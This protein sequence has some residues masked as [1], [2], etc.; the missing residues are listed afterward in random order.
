M[1]ELYLRF[2]MER[3][4]YRLGQSQHRDKFVLRGGMMLPL[5]AGAMVRPTKDIDLSGKAHNSVE[6][7]VG[8]LRDCLETAVPADGIEFN[9]ESIRGVEINKDAKYRGVRV[10]FTAYLGETRCS[11]QVDVGFGD[12][13]TDGPIEL[14][15]PVLLNTLDSPKLLVYSRESSIA[16]K[17]HA[18]VLM[19]TANTRMKDFFD[20]FHFARTQQFQGKIL[21]RAIEA[22]F[23]YR[24][25]E[26]PSRPPAALCDEYADLE[27]PRREWPP[28]LRRYRVSM[29][30][31]PLS[32][33]IAKL[34]EFL[35]PPVLAA[36]SS[37]VFLEEWSPEGP[38]K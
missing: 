12:V 35:M 32:K 13:V 37:R 3:F 18:M 8:L 19:D 38:W 10:F 11:M 2:A 22:T 33:V 15:Y 27:V 20:I 9:L 7:V 21:A 23:K 24:A 36:A 5:F 30:D 4:L 14:D 34:R 25:T 6:N 28:T 31:L 17:F 29:T 16:E 1:D 26:V